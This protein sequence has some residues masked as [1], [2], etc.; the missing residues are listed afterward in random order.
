MGGARMRQPVGTLKPVETNQT[1]RLQWISGFD[2]P[3]VCTVRRT[4][5][6]EATVQARQLALPRPSWLAIFAR[7]FALTS[8]REAI[9]RQA[10]LRFPW[11]RIYEH[12]TSVASLE[13]P[14]SDLSPSTCFQLTLPQPEQMSL[15]DLDYQ[16]RRYQELPPRAL[17]SLSFSFWSRFLP[18][19]LNRWRWQIQLAAQGYRRSINLG[20]FAVISTP[21]D[22]TTM[23]VPRSPLAWTF[24]VGTIQP[25]GEVEFLLSYDSRLVTGQALARILGTLEMVLN[26]EIVVELRY[27]E[28]LVEAA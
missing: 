23:V 1:L 3:S 10:F 11:P 12:P 20:T 16:I 7:A 21:G 6:I 8:Q 14:R 26:N 4:L 24:Q 15:V 19:W 5:H 18:R 25:L 9:L 13:I 22:G 28:R 17:T 2:S 27:L